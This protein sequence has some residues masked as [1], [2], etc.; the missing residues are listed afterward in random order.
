MILAKVF[1]L[2][3][4]GIAIGKNRSTLSAESTLFALTKKQPPS[5]RIRISSDREKQWRGNNRA[6]T[7]ILIK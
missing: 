3:I 5:I 2:K 7:I 6:I 1:A 4:K